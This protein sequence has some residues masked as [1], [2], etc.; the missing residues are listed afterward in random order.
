MNCQLSSIL[1]S[2]MPVIKSQIWNT[3]FSQIKK[4]DLLSHFSTM[5][6]YCFHSHSE[7]QNPEQKYQIKQTHR[8]TNG[9]ENFTVNSIKIKNF[10]LNFTFAHDMSPQTINFVFDGKETDATLRGYHDGKMKNKKNLVQYNIKLIHPWVFVVGEW[11]LVSPTIAVLPSTEI[12]LFDNSYSIST[13]AY[14]S[15][16]GQQLRKIIEDDLMSL[17]H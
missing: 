6:S 10:Y 4:S 2:R 3:I 8:I 17:V 14:V 16:Y 7:T 11:S 9:H 12:K 5:K 1:N 15:Q 13:R